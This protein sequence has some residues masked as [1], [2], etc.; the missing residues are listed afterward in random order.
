[1]DC[2]ICGV[3]MG[4]VNESQV[5]C[6]TSGACE[7]VEVVREI[8]W[9]V[10]EDEAAA[11]E[12]ALKIQQSDEFREFLAD[13]EECDEQVGDQFALEGVEAVCLLEGAR[14]ARPSCAVH[15]R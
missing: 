13:E 3:E 5:V 10:F 2:G 7:P 11:F 6:P 9:R 12:E 4:D 15:E 1:M 14:L 8:D